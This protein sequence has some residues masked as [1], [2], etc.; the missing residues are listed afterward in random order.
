MVLYDKTK[1]PP[2]PDIQVTIDETPLIRITE[3]L[4]L[5]IVIDK[6]LSFTPH[7]ELTTKK[8]RS[9]YNRLTLYPDLAPNVDLQ[10]YKAYIRSRLEYGCIIWSYKIDQKNHM[11]KLESAQ[12]GTLSLILRTMNSPPANAI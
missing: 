4:I 3:K 6:Q 10:L 8:C 12:R 9:A 11:K 5:E 2:P 7:V 1:L